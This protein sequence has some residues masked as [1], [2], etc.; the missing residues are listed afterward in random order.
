MTLS[1]EW[2]GL[3]TDSLT[4]SMVIE[5]LGAGDVGV[6]VNGAN[7]KDSADHAE[8]AQR[9]AKGPGPAKVC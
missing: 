7:T 3:G 8:C 9:G 1:E 2:G 6:S 5:E 4:T